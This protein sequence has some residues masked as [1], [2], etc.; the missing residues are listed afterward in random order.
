M[1]PVSAE[2]E[3]DAKVFSSLMML[4]HPDKGAHLRQRIRNL[5][6]SRDFENLNKHS[7]VL[8]LSDIDQVKVNE[9]EEDIDYNPEYTWAADTDDGQFVNDAAFYTDLDD[10]PFDDY[11]AERNIFNAIRFRGFGNSRNGF[12]SLYLKCLEEFDLAWNGLESLDGIEYCVHARYLDFSNNDLS[13]ISS[14]CLLS[15]V[16]ELYLENNLITYI[17]ALDNLIHLRILD[18]SGN[19]VNDITP[20]FNLENLEF[21]NLIG[22]PVPS[23]QIDSL[24][25]KG[26][27][28]MIQ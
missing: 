9:L 20:L 7:H 25:A 26:V 28:V 14:L 4:Y 3:K 24:R 5:Y 17:N 13:D 6:Y 16:E 1:S 23:S 10:N 27:L 21:V 12:S 2:E 15:D 22:N 19:Q 18:I 8:L 11:F